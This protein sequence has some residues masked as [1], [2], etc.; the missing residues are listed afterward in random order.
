MPDVSD[1][2]ECRQINLTYKQ[3]FLSLAP[4][5]M[6]GASR[7]RSLCCSLTTSI[8]DVVIMSL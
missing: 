2:R 7:D 4:T 1:A 8:K 3:K 5:E 6:V